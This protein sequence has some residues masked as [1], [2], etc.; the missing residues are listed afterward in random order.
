[1]Y[2]A[3]EMKLGLDAHS[4]DFDF[5]DVAQGLDAALASSSTFFVSSK[6]QLRLTRIAVNCNS[7]FK[8]QENR[9]KIG[10]RKNKRK[11]N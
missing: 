10:S 7:T 1:M 2:D 8:S 5:T 4:N 6:R 3:V 11:G 9:V